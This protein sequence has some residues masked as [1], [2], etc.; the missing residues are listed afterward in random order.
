MEFV[1]VS[2]LFFPLVQL[3]LLAGKRVWICLITLGCWALLPFSTVH[4]FKEIFLSIFLFFS[5]S[6]YLHFFLSVSLSFSH[7]FPPLPHHI[8]ASLIYFP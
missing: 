4:K 8:L 6:I 7:T 2:D 5:V 1:K 3:C